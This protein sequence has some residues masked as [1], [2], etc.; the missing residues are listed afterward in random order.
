M[1]FKEPRTETEHRI[2]LPEPVVESLADELAT[3]DEPTVDDARGLA[4]DRVDQSFQFRT[5]S[6][7]DLVDALERRLSN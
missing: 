1:S 4:F 7:E 5:E 2:E 6:G 3:V